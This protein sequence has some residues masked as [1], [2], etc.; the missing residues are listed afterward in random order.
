MKRSG[1]TLRVFTSSAIFL[2]IVL[3]VASTSFAQT[4]NKITRQVELEPVDGSPFIITGGDWQYPGNNAPPASAS[5]TLHTFGGTSV[6]QY[7]FNAMPIRQLSG[8]GSYS[9]YVTTQASPADYVHGERNS[10]RI[11][12]NTDWNGHVNLWGVLVFLTDLDA[13]TITL[14]IAYD[15]DDGEPFDPGSD[16]GRIVFSGTSMRE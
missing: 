5:G 7:R 13:P 16:M 10:G 9:L 4:E 3:A 11:Q 2:A 6:V 12:F 8:D 1:L 15:P 14:F